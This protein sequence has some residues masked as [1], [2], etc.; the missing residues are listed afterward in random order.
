[1]LRTT[2]ALVEMDC[3]LRN[4]VALRCAVSIGDDGRETMSIQGED[5]SDCMKGAIVLRRP[6]P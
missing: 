4:L 5:Y 1:M 3:A 2:A 6:W